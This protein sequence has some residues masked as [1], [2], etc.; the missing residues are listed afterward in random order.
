MF[1]LSFRSTNQS[2]YLQAQNEIKEILEKLE[3]KDV[4][5]EN[6]KEHYNRMMQLNYHIQDLFKKKA[7]E[8]KESV[9]KRKEK[10]LKN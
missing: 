6:S 2:L 1:L 7:N 5:L 10:V 4:D 3:N 8:I 9:L